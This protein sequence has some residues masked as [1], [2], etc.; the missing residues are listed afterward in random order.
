MKIIFM[1]GLPGSW[2]TGWAKINFGDRTDA[3]IL[4]SSDYF[5]QSG[6]YLFDG[7]K[8]I[9]SHLW[10]LQRFRKALRENKRIIVIDNTNIR[11]WEMRKYFSAIKTIGYDFKA[12]QKSMIITPEQSAVRNIHGVPLSTAIRMFNN[13]EQIPHI[14]EYIE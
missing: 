8:V 2:K 1:R 7:S 13:F 3:A 11:F 12:F 10:N 5:S 6:Q 14:P 4:S 9:A